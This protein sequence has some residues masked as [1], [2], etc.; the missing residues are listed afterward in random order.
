MIGTL[1]LVTRPTVYPVT[2]T[3]AKAQTKVDTSSEDTHIS[4]LIAAATGAAEQFLRR[5]L[6]QQTWDYLLDDWPMIYRAGYRSE[7]DPLDLTGF[8]IPLPRPPLQSVTHVKYVDT[9]G[10]LQTWSSSEYQVLGAGAYEAVGR[11][12][13]AWGYTFPTV[14]AQPEA[15]Q[16]RFVAGYADDGTSPTDLASGV[17][18]GIKQAVLLLVSDYFENRLPVGG[19]EGSTAVALLDHY[20]NYAVPL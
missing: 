16:I 14:R 9:A 8:A 12:V 17:P 18:N 2:L 6:V 4:A 7:R 10:T 3:E 5:A 11:L 15:I 1:K 19:L 20:R 13:A